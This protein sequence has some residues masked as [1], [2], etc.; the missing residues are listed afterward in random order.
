LRDDLNAALAR[1]WGRIDAVLA[2]YGVPLLPL[3]ATPTGAP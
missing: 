2:E 3:P 1:D